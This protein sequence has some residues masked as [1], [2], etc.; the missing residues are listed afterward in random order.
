MLVLVEIVYVQFALVADGGEDGRRV[1]CP[2][3]VTD[4]VLEVEGNDGALHILDP[5][6]DRPI[7]TA[8]QECL[9]VVW[10]PFDGVDGQI[11]VLVRLQVLA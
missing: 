11:M 3:N 7:S 2:L 9:R 8:A 4:L 10:V 5:H 6:L 1:R